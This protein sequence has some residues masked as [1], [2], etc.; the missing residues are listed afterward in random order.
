VDTNG[1]NWNYKTGFLFLG[2]GSVTV[3]V[4]FLLVPEP[5]MRNSAEMDEMYEKGVPAWRMSKYVTD[6]QRAAANAT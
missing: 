4:I 1:A 6:V 3:V 5:S 2:L